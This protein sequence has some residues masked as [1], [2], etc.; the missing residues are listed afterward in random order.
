MKDIPD[1]FDARKEW[2]D[3]VHP[4][5]DQEQCG[6]CWAFAGVCVVWC[7][8]KDCCVAPGAL[9]LSCA[10]PVLPP[11]LPRFLMFCQAL[12]RC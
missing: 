3:C 9:S 6:S 4:V 7:A 8:G 5:R 12:V 10:V 1:E 11:L 2:G